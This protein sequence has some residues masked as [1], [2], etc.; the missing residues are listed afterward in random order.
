MISPRWQGIIALLLLI[1]MAWLD[2]LALP[3]ML[4]NPAFTAHFHLANDRLTQGALMTVFLASYGLSAL[5]LTPLLESRIHHRRALFFCVLCW[6]L[7]CAASPLA[8]SLTGLVLMRSLAGA[9][10]GPLLSLKTRYINE[11][12]GPRESGKPNAVAAMGVTFGL[13]VGM[14][15]LGSL[16]S[17]VSW[18][19]TYYLLAGA[20]LVMGL[21]LVWAFIP[22]QDGRRL[23]TR[24]RFCNVL[25]LAWRTPL[26]GWLMLAEIATLSYL[27]GSTSW[28]PVWL[29]DEYQLS[30][31]ATGWLA[32]IP[33]LL[34]LIAKYTGGVLL[35]KLPPDQAP[36]IFI[37]AG[38]ATALAITGLIFS[39]QP[40]WLTFWLLTANACWGLQAAAIPVMI[41]HQARHE[42]VGSACGAINGVGHL[43]AAFIPLMMGSVMHS[44]GSMAAGFMILVAAQGVTLLAGAMMLLRLRRAAVLT[45]QA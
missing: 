28:L 38:A 45:L 17:S 40:P 32:A 22:L 31:S 16:I 24:L 13:A 34:C 18:S 2:R 41:Q 21:G 12:F 8:G 1:M 35:D 6:A 15:L 27:W 29:H 37:A 25:R 30:L 5:L 7:V 3:L 26:L 9:A 20:N 33:F 19:G 23:G 43:V 10:Q 11:H 4:L 39:S 42:V 14:P 44:L 36:L